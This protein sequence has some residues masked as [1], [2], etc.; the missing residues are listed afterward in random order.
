MP[1]Q[2][3]LRQLAQR[4]IGKNPAS[5]LVADALAGWFATLRHLRHRLLARYKRHQ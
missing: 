3:C 4:F 5:L 1:E 2:W